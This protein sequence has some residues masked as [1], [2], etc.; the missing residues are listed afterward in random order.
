MLGNIQLV[1][2]GNM[3]RGLLKDLAQPIM[4]TFKVQSLSGPPLTHPQY[5]LNPPR[6]QFHATAILRRLCSQLNEG[7][8]GIVGICDVDLFTPDADFVFGEADRE[9]RCAVVSIHRLKAAAGPEA[10]ARRAQAETVE[11]VGQLLGLSH[12]DDPHCAMFASR[13]P[14]DSDRKG[15]A[16]CND[17]RHELQRL[18]KVD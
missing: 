11:A 16:L 4:D 12:C 10:L 9:S 15:I 18:T 3:P 17:C 8:L 7:Q 14:A 1:T 5:A 2:V 6:K 13:T